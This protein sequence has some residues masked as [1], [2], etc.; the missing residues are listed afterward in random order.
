MGLMRRAVLS[1]AARRAGCLGTAP[2]LNDDHYVDVAAD[3]MGWAVDQLSQGWSA[4]SLCWLGCT[5]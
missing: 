2:F 1:D 3:E 5:Y 4:I